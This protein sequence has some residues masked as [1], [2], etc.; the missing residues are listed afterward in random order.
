MAKDMEG[1]QSIGPRIG[2]SHLA[3]NVITLLNA[4]PS[5]GKMFG[6]CD[7]IGHP[8][9]SL[10]GVR[11]ITPIIAHNYMLGVLSNDVHHLSVKNVCVDK[12]ELLRHL[13]AESKLHMKMTS[14]NY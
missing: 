3:G 12:L 5:V 10:L 13:K 1:V 7:Y 9:P 8:P 14:K 2:A 11:D 6:R 4:Q